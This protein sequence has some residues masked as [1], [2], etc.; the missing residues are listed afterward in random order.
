MRRFFSFIILISCIHISYAQEES[1]SS[2]KQIESKLNR[3]I[4][5]LDAEFQEINSDLNFYKDSLQ[6]I[7]HEIYILE[8]ESKYDD[9]PRVAIA[10]I[11]E[12]CEMR[13]TIGKDGEII[14][15]LKEGDT[16]I[17]TDYF[18]YRVGGYWEAIYDTLIGYI[19][20]FRIITNNDTRKVEEY[21]ENPLIDEQHQGKLDSLLRIREDFLEQEK[22]IRQAEFEKH[23][24]EVRAKELR[25]EKIFKAEQAR[26]DSIRKAEEREKKEQQRA[27]VEQ[28]KNRLI[29][30]Y[31]EVDA[32]RI[33]NGEYWIGMTSG[34][35]LESLG[36]P[37]KINETVNA[38]GKHQQWVYEH[39]YLYFDDGVL[40]SYQR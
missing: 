38:Y 3:K 39:L 33:L 37:Q 5:K 19:P 4:Q 40:T 11:D 28:R 22:K 26:F 15:N 17:L 25:E 27:K 34:M 31:G 2:L 29:L 10:V 1:L 35:A 9:Y 32:K 8:I 24:A 7:Q 30:F 21:S 23:M 16:V 18:D 6:K 13:N 20:Y 12:H 14:A 36:R